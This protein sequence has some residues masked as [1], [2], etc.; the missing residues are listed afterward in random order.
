MHEP[1]IEVHDLG[2]RYRLGGHAWLDQTLPEAIS[3]Q[4]RGALDFLRRSGKRAIKDRGDQ[5]WALRHINFSVN[6]GEVVGIIG[7][8]GAGKSTLLKI[9]SQITDPTEGRAVIR[10]RVASLLEVGTGF[11]PELTGREN[12]Y[13]NGSILGMTRREIGAKLDQIV[14]FSGIEKFLNTPIKRYSSGMTV[15][16]AF[17]V[18]AHLDPEILIIDEVLAV[19]DAAFQKKCLGKMQD[20]AT[21]GRTVLFVSHNMPMVQAIC[22]RAILLS[23]GRIVVEAAVPEVIDHYMGRT[24]ASSG[25]TYR[26]DHAPSRR[27]WI[28]AV[29]LTDEDHHA[30]DSYLMTQPIVAHFDLEVAVR[31]NLTLSIQIQELNHN[32]IFH[33][34]TVDSRFDVPSSP[35]RYRV[36]A[37]IPSTC[38]YPGDYLM[39]MTLSDSAGS[40]YTTLHTTPPLALEIRQDG[41]LC[42]RS[43]CRQAGL[44]HNVCHWHTAAPVSVAA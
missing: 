5:F 33:F 18:A 7:A 26:C 34:H 42:D 36:T 19:G 44:I 38:L 24:A 10:G 40:R 31:S 25:A 35:G 32:P 27:A 8:N 16:L 11:H 3:R 6:E 13:L 4:C 39:V 14:A 22:K 30:A 1:M 12:I 2:K 9:L 21:S 23:N 29:R 20:V 28:R 41:T 15:R 37:R 43:L 17:A